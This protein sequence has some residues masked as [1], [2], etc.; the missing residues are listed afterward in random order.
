MT[1]VLI[2]DYW[3][4]HVEPWLDGLVRHFEACG[5][6][7]EVWTRDSLDWAG[8]GALREP[9]LAPARYLARRRIHKHL[10]GVD[11]VFMW[12]GQNAHHQALR[13]ACA[14]AGIPCTI[15]EVGYFPQREWFT[16]D[17]LGINATSALMT[18]PLDWI[19]TPQLD[20][21]AALR[22]RYLKGR[23]WR[24][25][26]GYVLV[27]LQ[28]A[29][30]TNVRDHSDVC[31]MQDFITRCEA[32]FAGER[33]L[34]KVHP[35]DTQRYHTSHELLSD[36]DFLDLAVE[37]ERVVGINST[38]LLESALLGA[39]TEAL[40]DGF[41]RAHAHQTERLL[42][43]LVDKQVPVGTTEIDAWLE[44]YAAHRPTSRL[45]S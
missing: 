17:P 43:A 3:G 30:D 13:R 40:G 42:A 23:H 27:P 1:R 26:G 10:R 18:D 36:G 35:L 19:G 6:R 2:H 45:A 34:F 25:G 21:L 38:C 20:A 24:G 29:H 8:I 41:L 9:R 16:L 5:A 7:V 22:A 28:L 32:R 14:E 11:R 33:L 4:D 39:P 44:R 31:D 37:A 15:V 12:N